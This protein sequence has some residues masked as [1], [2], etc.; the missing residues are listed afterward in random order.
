MENKIKP[1][2]N[3]TKNMKTK[4]ALWNNI[5]EELKDNIFNP[6]ILTKFI[7]H[8]YETR[9]K[10]LNSDQHILF[11]FRIELI[12]SDIKTTTKLLKLDNNLENKDNLIAFLLEKINLTSESYNDTPI[13]S[14]IISY[15]IRKGKIIPTIKPIALTEK[16]NEGNKYQH[17][18]YNHK[19][20]IALNALDYGTLIGVFGDTTIVSFKKHYNLTIQS[21]DNKNHI[22]F[23]KNGVMIY[24]WT[25]HI[26]EDNSLMRE[27]GKTTFLWKDGEILWTKVLKTTKPIK[28]KRISSGLKENFITMDLETISKS[29]SYFI[30]PKQGDEGVR[31]IIY[32]AMKDICTRKYKGYKIY[33]HNFSKFDAIFLIKYLVMIG[34]CEPIIHKGKIIS[35]SFRPNWKKDFGKVTFYDS[36]LLLTSSLKKLGKSFSVETVKS[37]FPFKLNDINYKG[38]VPDYCYFSPIS[39]VEYKDYIKKYKDN[40]CDFI[41][42]EE[43]QN[44]KDNFKK[45]GKIWN[46]KAESIKYCALDCKTLFQILQKFNKQIFERFGLNI[47]DSPT[48]PSLA[49]NIFRSV[50]YKKEDIHQLSGKIDK[51][52][53]SGYTGGSTDMFIPKPPKGVKIYAYDVNSLY[54]SVMRD[55][56]FPIGTPTYFLPKAGRYF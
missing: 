18:Y 33:L 40:I 23:F 13:K 51:D 28:K 39:V 43:Y 26:K 29:Y 21:E 16:K 47:V 44:Y 1:K 12:N 53:R 15:G 25:D 45:G 52:I 30:D 42:P 7:N 9:I 54:P 31:N 37:I 19:L 56:L 17:I 48:L 36:Y 20:P 8:F 22:K 27:I 3:K 6:D 24:E 10:N 50:Y 35:F 5:Q 4:T 14:L 34:D 38:D 11:L 55:N 32:R 41:S 46:F 49:Y 2:L